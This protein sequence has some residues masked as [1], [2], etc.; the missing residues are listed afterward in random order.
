MGMKGKSEIGRFIAASV[1]AVVCM[2]NLVS[3]F[4]T[5]TGQGGPSYIGF[6]DAKFA[7]I[8]S[9]LT[10]ADS[11]K[12][13]GYLVE[14]GF[15]NLSIENQGYFLQAQYGLAPIFLHPATDADKFVILDAR[16]QPAPIVPSRFKAFKILGDGIFLLKA[17]Q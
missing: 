16:I 3:K 14:T 6:Y 2:L 10:R 15:E 13:V 11:A 17:A 8:R 1:L 7:E 5:S 12:T 9:E 4:M